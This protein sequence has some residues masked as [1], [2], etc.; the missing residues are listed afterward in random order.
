MNLFVCDGIFTKTM[1][2]LR[3]LHPR[4]YDRYRALEYHTRMSFLTFLVRRGV[5]TLESRPVGFKFEGGK[6]MAA[7]EVRH[8][9]LWS[10]TV[11]KVMF[12]QTSQYKKE[13][14]WVHTPIYNITWEDQ[15]PPPPPPPP[16]PPSAAPA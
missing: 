11:R 3:Q 7:E 2:S 12:E 16:P 4:E 15:G 8:P 6:V 9:E 13:V 10:G 1:P 5:I 14:R